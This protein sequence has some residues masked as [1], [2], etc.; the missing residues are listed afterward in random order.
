MCGGSKSS[1]KIKETPEQKELAKIAAERYNHAQTFKPYQDMYMA[2][3]DKLNTTGAHDEA[4]GATSMAFNKSF[5]EAGDQVA[6]KVGQV[7][8]PSSGKFQTA[9]TGLQ[10]DRGTAT[11]DAMTKTDMTQYG[12]YAKGLQD[13]VAIGQKKATDA[14]VGLGDVAASSQQMAAMD[15]SNAAA[16]RGR[17]SDLIGT[18]GGVAGRMGLNA[19][20][21][22]NAE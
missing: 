15:A 13:V 17:N 10:T 18:V 5:G 20:E 14:Q 12:R 11:G 9:M 2:R 1:N 3:V 7:A 21:V 16:S 8:D 19:I 22:N 6:Q 4:K